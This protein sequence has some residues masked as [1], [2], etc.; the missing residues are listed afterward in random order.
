M[1]GGDSVEQVVGGSEYPE[2]LSSAP[3]SVASSLEDPGGEG[4]EA[5]VAEPV[6]FNGKE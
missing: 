1:S 6:A 3:N 2:V 5:P 4:V